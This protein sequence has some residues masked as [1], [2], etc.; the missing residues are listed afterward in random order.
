MQVNVETGDMR[1][2]S[3]RVRSK[4]EILLSPVAGIF[5]LCKKYRVEYLQRRLPQVCGKKQKPAFGGLCLFVHFQHYCAGAAVVESAAAA[6]VSAAGVVVSGVV[7]A[8]VS[9]AAAGV[10]AAVV[11]EAGWEL[12]AVSKLKR[13]AEYR[14]FFMVLNRTVFFVRCEIIWFI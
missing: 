10:S 13:I 9:V 5:L 4:F 3:R 12:H 11:S 8:G 2:F 14:R 1:S 6:V 7:A